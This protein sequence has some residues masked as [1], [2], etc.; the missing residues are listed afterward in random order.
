MA[1]ESRKREAEAEESVTKRRKTAEIP[2][3]VKRY[4]V[5][6]MG[7]V[8]LI[9]RKITPKV[10]KGHEYPAIQ[11]KGRKR[12][13]AEIVLLTFGPP[14][15][16]PQHTVG[17]TNGK[18]KSDASLEGLAWQDKKEQRADQKKRKKRTT[19]GVKGV[20]A[21]KGGYEEEFVSINEAARVL[22]LGQSP[23]RQMPQGAPEDH[24]Q[25]TRSSTCLRC[26]ME[27]RSAPCLT[28]SGAMECPSERGTRQPK[29]ASFPL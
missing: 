10:S 16:S 23:N 20:K 8:Q 17:H 3:A 7:R 19:A 27:R 2:K 15:P 12:Y 25:D 13:L 22:G 18:L 5:S 11:I 21:K 6:N 9:G 24:R 4:Q 14:R 1:T 26:V 28:S 29:A